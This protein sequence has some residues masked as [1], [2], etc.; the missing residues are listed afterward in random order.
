MCSAWCHTRA[1][2]APL[3]FMS[4]HNNCVCL[5]LKVTIRSLPYVH[6]CIYMCSCTHTNL[7]HSANNVKWV[8]TITA[9]YIIV[10]H[11]I[12]MSTNTHIITYICM[13]FL[14]AVCTVLTTQCGLLQKIRYV[15]LFDT[16]LTYICI[17]LL[18]YVRSSDWVCPR[19]HLH[20]I[21]RNNTNIAGDSLVYCLYHNVLITCEPGSWMQPLSVLLY[22]CTS[23]SYT[24]SLKFILSRDSYGRFWMILAN[25]IYMYICRIVGNFGESIPRM[26]WRVLNLATWQIPV[27]IHIIRFFQNKIWRILNLATFSKITNLPN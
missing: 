15:W 24:G 20:H 17:H 1:L 10:P 26:N 4:T 9:R 22:I 25:I 5:Y 7:T 14:H 2:S 11:N 16:Y 13:Y 8:L 23:Y 12:H 3:L 19:V 6:T 27:R 18:T 21:H